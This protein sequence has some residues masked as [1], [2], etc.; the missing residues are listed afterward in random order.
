VERNHRRSLLGRSLGILKEKV[1]GTDIV[2]LLEALEGPHK[3]L[4][5][6]VEKCERIN[7]KDKKVIDRFLEEQVL[8]IFEIVIM[9]LLDI[10]S[11][12]E[13]AKLD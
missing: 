4:H 7:L 8:P 13:K 9:N 12:I 3:N 5:D 1:K 10:K 2:G 6:L 11:Q